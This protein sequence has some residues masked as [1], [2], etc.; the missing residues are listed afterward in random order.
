MMAKWTKMSKSKGNVVL[1]EEVI[2]GVYELSPGHEFRGLDGEVVDWEK[3]F[4]WLDIAGY[5][6]S[7]KYGRRPVFLHCKNNP[8]PCWLT[9]L[10]KL[11][12][13]DEFGFWENLVN[14]QEK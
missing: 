13:E 5:R 3:L 11:Q 4:I 8:V 9:A 2:N 12:H 14:N 6:T 10:N 7:T 1:P